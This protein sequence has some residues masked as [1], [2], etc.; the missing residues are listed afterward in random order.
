[1]R[2]TFPVNKFFFKKKKINFKV[3]KKKFNICYAGNFGYDN[4]LDDLLNL[5]HIHSILEF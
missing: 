5:I 1:M 3:N 4:H 2:A